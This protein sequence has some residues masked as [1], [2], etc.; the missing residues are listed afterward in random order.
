MTSIWMFGRVFGYTRHFPIDNNPS[1]KTVLTSHPRFAPSLVKA[2]PPPFSSS[3]PPSPSPK[4]TAWSVYL[5][6]CLRVVELIVFSRRSRDP[7][8]PL[9][10][11]PFPPASNRRL[12][13][14]PS[15][16]P[17]RDWYQASATESHRHFPPQPPDS[18]EFTRVPGLPPTYTH[19]PA[20]SS[21]PPQKQHPLLLTPAPLYRCSVD[22][23]PA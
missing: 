3:S 11:R 22:I 15:A 1:L 18:V 7:C 13:A 4:D 9:P 6:R 20:T 21:R 10:T 14:A 19:A 17:T 16:E 5:R 12:T 23:T 2:P 8:R